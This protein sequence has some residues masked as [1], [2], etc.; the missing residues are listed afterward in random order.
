MKKRL[1]WV[2]GLLI[3]LAT[4]WAFIFRGNGAEQEIQYRYEAVEVGTLI[5]SIEATGVLVAKTSVDV[6]SKAGGKIIRLAVDEGTR[7]AAGQLIAV[8]DPEDTQATYQQASAD[9]QSSSARAEQAKANYHLQVANSRTSVADARVALAQAE[10]RLERAR[11]QTGMQPALTS[12]NVRSAQAGYDAAISQQTKIERV[13]VPQMRRDA[14]SGLRRAKTDVDTAEA[15]MRRS[16]DLFTRG[17]VSQAD[18]DRARSALASARSSFETAQQRS[19]T[20]E[21][22]VQALQTAQTM[23]VARARSTLEQAKANSSDVEIS[24]TNLDEAE[25]AVRNA[26]INV[27]KAIDGQM[28]N[29]IRRQEMIAAGASTV[30]SQVSVK[31]ARVQLD[32]TTVLAPRA[33][34]VTQK[35]LEE[36]TIIPPGASTFSQGT[37]LVQISDTTQMF[38]ECAVDEADIGSVRPGQPVQI[39][40]EAF[41]G[42]KFKGE[43]ERIN[44]AARTE[45]SVTAIKVR[46]RILPGVKLDLRPGLNATCEFIVLSKPNVLVL[47]AQA[48]ERG[49]EGSTVLVKVAGSE[50]PVSRAVEVGTE[51]NNGLEIIKGL[52]AGDE[53]VVGKVDVAQMKEIQKRMLEAKEG[54]GLAGGQMGGGRNLGGGG[55][56]RTGG[57]GGGTGRTGGGGGSGGA[58]RASGAPRGG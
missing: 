8:I 32:S 54:G 52:E 19:Q 31:N 57:G 25:E 11:V 24:K 6:K 49:K 15:A 33:G 5:R 53:V 28:Q 35:Y 9:L 56:G 30:R 47:P 10:I 26:R 43:V 13:T 42:E 7:V 2:V 17:F 39:M 37:S 14:E 36:G 3:V 38:V 20:I 4:V 27:Q 55:G 21:A 58:S 12:A 16:E 44:P 46:V 50:Q 48:L 40:T 34:V 1:I 41:P 22:E 51:G 18:V 45:S 23:E 29:D